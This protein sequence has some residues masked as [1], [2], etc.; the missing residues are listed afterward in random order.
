MYNIHPST[1][2]NH[3]YCNKPFQGALPHDALFL[4][5]GLDANYDAQIATKPIFS[6]IMEY[7]NDGIL[8]WDKYGVHHPFLLSEYSGCGQFYH[9]S[10]SR[11]GFGPQHAK[12]VSFV[13]LLH[14][15][16]VGRNP[17]ICASDLDISHLKMLNSAILEGQAKYIFVSNSVSKLMVATGVFPWLVTKPGRT[18]DPIEI[19]YQ[20]GEKT[21]Y[22]HLHFSVY[23]KFQ[24]QKIKEAAFIRSLLLS[25]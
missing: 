18:D 17:E 4:F 2:L 23:G 7:H 11:I 21:V 14:V 15:P 5:I 13:E 6:K 22:K 25:V 24:E 12:L 9:K 16:T 3:I 1:Q 8:F 20:R 10:F 19:L